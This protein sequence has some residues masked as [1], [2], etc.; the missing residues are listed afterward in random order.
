MAVEEE[1]E[2]HTQSIENILNKIIRE[3]ILS[4]KKEIPSQAQEIFRI[5]TR[6]TE[7]L[8]H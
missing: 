4:L 6:Q 5:L 8:K 1:K 3:N 7:K 2:H